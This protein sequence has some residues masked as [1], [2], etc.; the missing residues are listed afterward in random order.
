[1][2]KD[3]IIADLTDAMKAKEELKLS[4]LRMLKAAIMNYEVSGA[5]MKVTDEVVVDLVK[6]G[7]KQ[8]REAS[9]GFEKGGNKEAA[10]KELDEIKILEKYMPEQ[11]GE[12]EVKKIV[13]EVIGQVKPAGP[14]DF[15]KVMGAVMGKLK[16]QADGNVVSKVVKELMG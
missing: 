3:Q 8:R 16:G 13:Q 5:D 4:T 2:L 10:Q 7:I 1:M 9:E 11:M 14:Q 12:D 6:K 15:G